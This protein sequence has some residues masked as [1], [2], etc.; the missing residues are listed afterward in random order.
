MAT[1]RQFLGTDDDIQRESQGLLQATRGEVVKTLTDL[2]AFLFVL[3]DFKTVVIG[4]EEVRLF[5]AHNH[6]AVRFRFPRKFYYSEAEEAKCIRKNS[7]LREKILR[8]ITDASDCPTLTTVS[9]IPG[10]FDHVEFSTHVLR[11]CWRKELS[12]FCSNLH[13]NPNLRNLHIATELS[14]GDGFHVGK[15]LLAN[16][17]LVELSLPELRDEGWTDLALGLARNRSIRVLTLRWNL[18]GFKK[19]VN[20]QLPPHADYKYSDDFTTWT[21]CNTSLQTLI[22]SCPPDLDVP[23]DAESVAALLYQV[24][25]V[26]TVVIEYCPPEQT[27]LAKFASHIKQALKETTNLKLL[28]LHVPFHAKE[29]ERVLGPLIPTGENNTLA[30]TNSTLTGLVLV[31]DRW[32]KGDLATVASMLRRNTTLTGFGIRVLHPKKKLSFWKYLQRIGEQEIVEFLNALHE[33]TS[34]RFLNLQGWSVVDGKKVLTAV[35]DLLRQ[36]PCLDIDLTGTGLAHK[37]MLEPVISQLHRNRCQADQN[38]M[39]SHGGSSRST[40]RSFISPPDSTANRSIDSSVQ[41]NL[42]GS[43]N[44]V[45]ACT[46]SSDHATSESRLFTQESVINEDN[47]EEDP[48]SSTSTTSASRSNHKRCRP[49]PMFFSSFTHAELEQATLG[50]T[51]P[52]GEGGFGVVYEGELANGTRVAVKDLK[53]ANMSPEDRHRI[54]RSF[55]AEVQT[56]GLIHHVN[57]VRLL[58]YCTEEEHH[59]LVYEFMPNSSLDKWLFGCDPQRILDWPSRMHIAVKIARGL[60]Y[61]HM[62]C[63]Q[64]VVHLDV[65]PQNILLDANLN[66]KLA[67]FGIARLMDIEEN[68]VG[69]SLRHFTFGHVSVQMFCAQFHDSTQLVQVFVYNS[70]DE[71]HVILSLVLFQTCG[72]RGEYGIRRCFIA[73]LFLMFLCRFLCTIPQFHND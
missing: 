20:A 40:S 54:Q 60:E 36:Q 72:H 39:R 63:S 17:S 53:L 30:Q 27:N 35:L 21:V 1:A 50:F 14:D 10:D 37:N 48:D 12:D 57:L 52:L 2:D 65:K 43:V 41:E 24:S 71:V 3:K 69:I 31:T 34:L 4:V 64:T 8:D 7:S 29:L 42:V 25:C 58:G 56:L 66:P 6:E 67:D 47:E 26:S 62:G 23:S 73:T 33:N 44:N 15:L 9:F 5:D 11:E 32:S 49:L 68:L 28:Y 59:M 13:R 18:E 45:T 51:K 19:L 70:Q 38:H 22:V 46:T 16:S 61:L 55:G